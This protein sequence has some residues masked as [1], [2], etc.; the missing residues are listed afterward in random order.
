MADGCPAV[1]RTFRYRLYPTGRQAQAL[2]K[3]LGEACDLYNAALEQ[4][5]RIWREHGVSVGYGDQSAELRDLRACGLLE[6]DANFW[7]Q[8]AVLRRLDRAFQAFYRRCKAGGAP[9]YPRFRSRRRYDTLD[10]SFAGNAGGIGL[11]EAG[12]LRVQGVGHIKVKLHR[13]IPAG[14][15]LCE[16]RITRRSGRWYVAISLKDV[17]AR[18][19]PA[20]GRTVGVDVGITTFA[21]TSGGELILGPRANRAASQAVKRAQRKV[22]RRRRGSNRWRKAVVLLAR[23]RECEANVRRDHAHKTAR[24]LIERYDTICVEDLNHVGLAK[25]TLARDCNDQGW[26]GFIGL[27]HEKAEEAARQLVQVD[28]RLHESGLLGVRAARPESA[29]RARARVLLRA[30]A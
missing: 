22:A 14:A 11:T 6:A 29:W 23:A 30:R 27:L 12:R 26:A 9:G 3:Q 28:P 2:D 17:P 10:Y 25:G 4:R 7:S 20:T 13:P 1:R 21:A 24:S 8:Q 16:A 15:A 5:R 19:L 18:P